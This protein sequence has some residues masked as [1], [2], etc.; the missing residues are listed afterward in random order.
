MTGS[1]RDRLPDRLRGPRVLGVVVLAIVTLIAVALFF[2]PTIETALAPGETITAEFGENYLGKIFEGETSVKLSG[3]EAGRVVTVGETD[4]RT[5]LVDIKVDSGVV[6]EL[7]PQPSATIT[8]RTL[9]GGLYSIELIPGGGRGSFPAESTIPLERTSI[10]VGVE[11]ILESLPR[12][13]REAV[14]GVVGSVD[15]AMDRG[16][17]DEL[18]RLLQQGP[19]A[20]RPTND[21]LRAAEGTRPGVDLPQV[22][23]NLE[24]TAT[25][26]TRRDGELGAIV[27]DLDAT[28]AVL[29]RGSRPLA[30]A[31]RTM[32]QTLR[33]T[34]D[35]LGDLRGTLLKLTETAE[36][37]RPSAKALAPAVR[38]LEPVL[39]KARPVVRDLRPLLEDARPVVDKLSPVVDKAEAVLDDV[40]GPVLDRVRGPVLDTLL[41]TFDGSKVVVPNGKGGTYTPFG[42]DQNDAANLQKFPA[43]GQDVYQKDHKF[44]EELAYLVSNLDRGS[45]TLDPNGSLL[46]FQVGAGPLSTPQGFA[47]LD[48]ARLIQTL[49]NAVPG[50]AAARLG[51]VAPAVPKLPGLPAAPRGPAQA[52]APTGLLTGGVR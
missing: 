5:A 47:Q 25:I 7:G 21:V 16:A 34:R 9:L 40:E 24:A 2:K 41:N 38:E 50:Q 37:F 3:L 43:S 15:A 1:L 28:T 33:V 19:P 31:I 51:S 10:P 45:S 49:A 44:Y 52:P 30:E 23:S 26:L 13:T 18:R 42:G 48:F 6:D 27:D 20:L 8:P 35:G 14:R 17:D 29:D 46:G 22:V 11:R 12:P 39:E 36:D 32:P 4:R